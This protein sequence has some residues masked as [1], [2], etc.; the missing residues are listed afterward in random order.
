MGIIR[1][2]DLHPN[3][4]KYFVYEWSETKPKHVELYPDGD[5]ESKEFFQVVKTSGLTD[6]S[7][8]VC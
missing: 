7:H 3:A 8:A 2:D 5:F 4:V 1:E 6:V